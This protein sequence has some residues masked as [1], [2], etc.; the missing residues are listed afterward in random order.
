[1]HMCVDYRKLNDLTR[2]D[3]TPLLQIDELLDSLY[4]AQSFG[5]MD[6]YK[7][8]HHVR[9]KQRDI[10]ITAFRTHYGMFEYCVLP[11]RLCNAPYGFQAMM[12][13]VLAPYLGKFRV[14]YLDDV[15]LIYCK[16]ADEHL[17]HIRL[18]LREQQRHHLHI[19][20]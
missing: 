20:L 9:V 13:R 16:T 18:V 2:K 8:Y 7:A 19:K 15:V 17:E 5:K 12:N 11:F 14:V 6:V 4:G 10:H 1:M 3:R